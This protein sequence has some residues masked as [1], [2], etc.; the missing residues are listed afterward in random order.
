MLISTENRKLREEIMGFDRRI[1]Q[2]H[3][4]FQTYRAGEARKM[5]DWERLDREL[6]GFSRRKIFDLELRNHL[7]RVMYK[8]QNRKKIWL[9]WAEEYQTSVVKENTPPG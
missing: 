7:D 4:D 1:E 2:M 5:P 8:F 9:K 6:L 3:I